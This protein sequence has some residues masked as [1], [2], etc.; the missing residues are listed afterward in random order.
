MPAVPELRASS[1]Y[2]G[3]SRGQIS[4]NQA[5][6]FCSRSKAKD[7]ASRAPEARGS[8]ASIRK[9][10]RRGRRAA[11]T[12]GKAA[13]SAGAGG[14]G[15]QAADAAPCQVPK[16]Q[17][18]GNSPIALTFHGA[19]RGDYGALALRRWQGRALRRSTGR[20][21]CQ[22]PVSPRRHATKKPVFRDIRY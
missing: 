14:A 20:P 22:L 6:Y 17:A 18:S 13:R 3:G 1:R 5:T 19:R 2:Q 16:L 21:I 10:R 11:A 15:G 4:N 9:R 12:G 8:T 7:V